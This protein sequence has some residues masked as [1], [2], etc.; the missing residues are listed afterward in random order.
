MTEEYVMMQ[1]IIK[2]HK[3]R[4]EHLRKYYP[5]FR[6]AENTFT[7]YK[8]GKFAGLD[9]GYITMAT[10]RFFI[11]ENNFHESEITYEQYEGFLAEILRREF[12]LSVDEAE[13]KELIGYIFDKIKNDGKA[14]TFSYFDPEGKKKK[15]ARVKLIDSRIVDGT[16]LY[17]VTT[18]GIEFYLD[19]KEI[20]D[21]SNISV[22]Q[23][24]L[25]KMIQ[26][27]NFAGGIEVIKRINNEVGRLALQKK[28]VLDLLVKNICQQWQNGLTRKVSSL[29][30]TGH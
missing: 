9:M 18:D 2:D 16:V 28:E 29:R 19:T 15:T 1:D 12:A 21:E 8:E 14:F 26:S 5:F 13:E 24:L 11:N 3:E 6:L 25:E 30:R 7:W 20:K 22:Q 27:E 17:H 10:L 4:M 23:L